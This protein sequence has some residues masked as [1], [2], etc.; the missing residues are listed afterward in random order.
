MAKIFKDIPKHWKWVTLDTVSVTSSGG[1]PDRKNSNYFRGNIPWVKS[2]ELNYKIISKTEEY[3]TQEAVNYSSA[4]VFPKGSLLIAL[5]GNTVGRMAF[6]GVDAATNQAVAS[7]KSFCINAKY[8]YYYLMSSKE[9]LL[10]KREGSAQ[11]NISQKVLSSFPFP[12]APIEEQN[13]IV[14]KIEELFSLIDKSN[15]EITKSKERLNILIKKSVFNIFNKI[16]TRKP[17]SKLAEITMGQSPSSTSFN[18]IGKGTPFFQGKK[19]FTKMYPIPEKYTTEPIR[20]AQKNNILMSVRAP[21]GS[22]NIANNDCAIGRG[23]CAIEFQGFYKYLFYYL[24][25]IK[26]DLEQLGTGSTFNSISKNIIE[27]I[28]IPYLETEEQFFL[29][30]KLETKIETYEDMINE[31]N[32]QIKNNEILKLK[33]LNDAFHGKLSTQLNSD[34]SIDNLLNNIKQEKEEYLFNQQEIIK[35]RPKIKRM[36]KE[37]L[38]IIQVLE[39]NKK[40]I[41]PKQ[42]WED[43]MY[44]DSIEKFYSELKKVQDRVIEERTEKGS[45]ISLK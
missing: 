11:P 24:N 43:S 44:S 18:T 35:N 41:S 4:K 22:V 16:K 30:D 39:K 7:I 37:K 1:T 26:S 25:N 3:I 8:L 2:G 31:I 40:P 42:L 38:S 13:R 19:E 33:I 28:Q 27:N 14:D 6:L 12:L 23:L 5:Y 34:T 29:I 21:V 36:E 45:L 10:N 9:E 20:L 32:L 17:L 15:S